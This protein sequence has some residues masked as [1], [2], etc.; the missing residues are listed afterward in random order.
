MTRKAELNLL[1]QAKVQPGQLGR[2]SSLCHTWVCALYY[3]Q[4]LLIP[5]ISCITVRRGVNQG[6]RWF[7]PKKIFGVIL[8]RYHYSLS[9]SSTL[10]GGQD[11][12]I[13][14]S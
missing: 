12:E 13:R 4:Q 3:Q 5:L 8:M 7:L 6:A 1:G 11:G 9:T 14:E 10:Q 2:A